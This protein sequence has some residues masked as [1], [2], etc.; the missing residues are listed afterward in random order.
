MKSLN[1]SRIVYRGDL[2]EMVQE[3]FEFSNKIK[4]FEYA[5]R[6]PGT[7]IIL[8]SPEKKMLLT[9]EYRRELNS[10][11]IRLPGGKVF[12]SL[13]EF[14]TARKSNMSMLDL[15]KRAAKRELEEETGFQ[16]LQLEFI[17]ISKC[18]ATIQWDL[19][20][21]LCTSWLLPKE[22]FQTQEGEDI[23]VVWENY[24]NAKHFC[25]DGTISEERSAIN[26]LR[27][28]NKLET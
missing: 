15:A 6:G 23:S 20:Y 9:R 12:D 2:F 27:Y 13:A 16:A 21:F 18:G 25:L 26:I 10:Y 7:R 8:V 17:A 4:T 24:S 11:D 22:E 1:N 3:D 28:L 5:R 19:Y 14:E